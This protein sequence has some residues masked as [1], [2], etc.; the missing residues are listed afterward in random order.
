MVFLLL[1]VMMLTAQNKKSRTGTSGDDTQLAVGP[2]AKWDK[3]VYKMGELKYKV[4]RD[5]DFTLTNSGNV[6]LLITYAQASCGCTNLQYSEAPI[7]PGKST[8][9]KVTYDASNTGDFLK[10]ITVVTN[11]STDPTTLQITGTVK[12]QDE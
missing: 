7:L 5:A 4:P 12:K 10:T 9:I 8:T 1:P 3:T 2:Q 6:P 11:A